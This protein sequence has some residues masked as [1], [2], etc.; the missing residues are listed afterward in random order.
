MTTKKS[1]RKAPTRAR[2]TPATAAKRP[3]IVA[4]PE[5]RF[6]VNHGPILKDL[7]ELRDGLDSGISDEQLAHH[8][9]KQKNDFADWVESILGDASCAK[10]MRRL[11][12]RKSLLRAVDTHLARYRP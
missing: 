4:P 1:A 2:R 5:Q 7:R 10:A 11:R 8:V 3:L 12:T 6:W 9:S